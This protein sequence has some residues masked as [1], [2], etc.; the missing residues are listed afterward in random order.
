MNLENSVSDI[1]TCTV[2][3][4]VVACK[5]ETGKDVKTDTNTQMRL[6]TLLK[7]Q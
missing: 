5:W 4:V 6:V 3:K 2:E 7:K 1:E